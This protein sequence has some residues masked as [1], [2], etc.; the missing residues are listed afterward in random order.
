MGNLNKL[1]ELPERNANFMTIPNIR[2]F[3]LIMA[4]YLPP[5]NKPLVFLPCGRAN[6][7]RTQTDLRKYI[8]QGTTHQFMSKV[9]RCEDY[10]KVII[11]EPLTLI[12]YSYESHKLRPDY[13]VPPSALSIQCEMIF[14]RQL[15]L[16]LYK[17]RIA[18]PERNFIYYCG[19]F[20]HYFILFYANKL[21]YKPFQI[22]H[23]VAQK[24]LI[25]Y[26][27][28]AE[29]LVKLINETESTKIMPELPIINLTDFLNARGRY[30][31]K[32]FWQKIF[33]LQQ[34]EVITQEI[35]GENAWEEGFLPLYESMEGMKL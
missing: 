7:T 29:E 30:T 17:L 16:F 12:P 5:I 26:S 35:C 13:N 10:E 9:T 19:A 24:G 27:K 11:S 33:M 2:Y 32:R 21:L 8:S 18:Q 23:A 25:E 3:N 14:I 1:K 4:E 20:H 15:A 31:N 6:K 28:K 34:K 22:V